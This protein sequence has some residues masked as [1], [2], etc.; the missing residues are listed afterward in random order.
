AVDGL[1]DIA[2]RFAVI[3]RDEIEF[4]AGCITLLSDRERWTSLHDGA[5]EAARTR[6]SSQAVYQALDEAMGWG[7]RSTACPG[8][9]SEESESTLSDVADPVPLLE[10]NPNDQAALFTLGKRLLQANQRDAG[11]EIVNRVATYRRGDPKVAAQAARLALQIGEYW[12]AVVH[13]ATVIGEYPALPEV[14]IAPEHQ[15][16][17]VLLEEALIRAGREADAAIWR[18]RRAPDAEFGQ[19]V[20][21][22]G[23]HIPKFVEGF[24]VEGDG[25]LSIRSGKGTVRIV[26]PWVPANRISLSLD[27]RRPIKLDQDVAISLGLHKAACKHTISAYGPAVQTMSINADLT[28]EAAVGTVSL[29]LEILKKESLAFPLQLIGYLLEADRQSVRS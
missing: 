2:D 7:I 5:L 27:V 23:P 26:L 25:N 3:A 12:R 18:A 15:R 28:D 19:Y 22:D 21:L 11:W 1:E 17:L 4:T 24:L 9:A 29:S 6:F 10:A 13:A 8:A 20:T 16:L 14:L